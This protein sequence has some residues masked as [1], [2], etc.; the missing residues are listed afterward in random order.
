MKTNI[1]ILIVIALSI[2]S[3][4]KTE[5]GGRIGPHGQML[6]FTDVYSTDSNNSIILYSKHLGGHSFPHDYQDIMIGRLELDQAVTFNKNQV[7]HFLPKDDSLDDWISGD[8]D[9]FTGALYNGTFYQAKIICNGKLIRFKGLWSNQLIDNT[10]TLPTPK[11]VA[12]NRIGN[13]YN[14]EHYL[15]GK[16]NAFTHTIRAE[17]TGNIL[18]D[19]EIIEFESLKNVKEDKLVEGKDYSAK[20]LNRQTNQHVTVK[21]V[22]YYVNPDEKKGSLNFLESG[23]HH[24]E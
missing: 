7:Y 19:G 24:D 2:M 1:I 10:P 23:C 21:N 3:S 11:Y 8:L 15:E 5:K 6:F 12:F 4:F 16:D 20:I 9:T 14:L 22:T 17:I 13:V 18:T